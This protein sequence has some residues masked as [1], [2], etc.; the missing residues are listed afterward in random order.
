MNCVASGRQTAWRVPEPQHKVHWF[1][2]FQALRH[3]VQIVS[4]M[5]LQR[6]LFL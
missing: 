6:V 2:Q 4:G 1:G 3:F 5:L